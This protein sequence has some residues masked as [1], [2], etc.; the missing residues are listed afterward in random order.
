M[1]YA[2]RPFRAEEALAEW[3]RVLALAEK[4]SSVDIEEV[5]LNLGRV[6][7]MAAR[8]GEAQKWLSKVKSPVHEDI[9]NVLWLRVTESAQLHK[10]EIGN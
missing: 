6:D 5:Y 10:D 1:H 2:V 3:D 9:R 4:D 7:Y 8:Y